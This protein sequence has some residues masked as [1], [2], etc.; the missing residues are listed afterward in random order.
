MPT[1]EKK[2]NAVY[3][4]DGTNRDRLSQCENYVALITE[5]FIEKMECI[6][7]MRDAQALKIPMFALIKRGVILP[8]IVKKANWKAMIFF[9][10][11][12]DFE[13]AVEI[14]KIKMGLE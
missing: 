7:E 1:D 9:S 6:N 10:G 4:G 12:K 3:S 14:L 11:T 5:H 13:V 8:D 2:F